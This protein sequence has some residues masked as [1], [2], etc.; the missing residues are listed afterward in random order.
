MKTDDHLLLLK[1]DMGTGHLGASGRYDYLRELAFE[2]AFV[3]RSL[4]IE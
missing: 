3:L 1:T 4:G 2:Y